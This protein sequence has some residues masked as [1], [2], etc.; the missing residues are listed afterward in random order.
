MEDVVKWKD[1]NKESFCV[2]ITEE[3]VSHFG[4]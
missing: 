1:D 3:Q 2:G 4:M